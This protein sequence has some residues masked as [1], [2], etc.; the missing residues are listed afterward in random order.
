MSWMSSNNWLAR[1]TEAAAMLMEWAPISVELRT[2]LA[3]A[4]LRWNNWLRV[5]PR[6]PACSAARTA[7]LS[8]P[9][10]WASPN[11]MESRPLATRK[12]WRAASL[13]SSKYV[14]A[15]SSEALTPPVWAS[16]VK[17]SCV[18]AWS[19]AQYISVRLQVDKMAASG[20][21]AI[22]C[23]K[24]RR[25]PCRVGTSLSTANANRPR[26]SSGAVVWFKPRVHTAMRGIIGTT[27]QLRLTLES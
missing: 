8:W 26:R 15:C 20:S 13:P 11:T 3:T 4:K 25:K 23:A 16:Q 18:A 7:S 10:I 19:A 12:A 14:W 1:R 21:W 9:R 5:L 17:V 27:C 2:S 24:S 22:R 6:A